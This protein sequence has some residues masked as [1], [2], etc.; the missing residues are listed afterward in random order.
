VPGSVQKPVNPGTGR[1]L[2]CWNHATAAARLLL[3]WL[4]LKAN[5]KTVLFHRDDPKTEK[6]CPGTNVSKDW[7][8]EIV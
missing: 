4:G 3:D 8:L 6:T 7:V 5:A 1:G 2:A